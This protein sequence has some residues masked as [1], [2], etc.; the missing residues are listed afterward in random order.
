[1]KRVVAVLAALMM[2][3]VLAGTASAYPR[4]PHN[5]AT[6][7][8][9]FDWKISRPFTASYVASST[10]NVMDSDEFED[11]AKLGANHDPTSATVIVHDMHV[12]NKFAICYVEAGAYQKGFPDDGNFAVTDYGAT[13]SYPNQHFNRRYQMDGYPDEYYLNIAGFAGYTPGATL[14]GTAANI[15]TALGQRIA[16]CHAEGMDGVEPDDLDGYT[17]DSASGAMGGG[18]RLTQ[19]EAAG[20]EQWLAYTAHGDSMAIFQKNDGANTAADYRT[21]DGMI[22]EE[23]NAY[24]DPCGADGDNV[25]DYVNAGKPVLNAE[26]TQDGE[27]T[28]QFC[29]ADNALGINGSLFSVDLDGSLY[30]SCTKG[31]GYVYGH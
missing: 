15:A 16:G 17:N 5:S 9:Q 1:M 11:A 8:V 20:F 30:A 18:W 24:D 31:R 22:I 23:C 29:S 2:T 26:Y 19:A 12:A 27:T 14:T 6:V 10:A 28:A 21:F 4:P 25:Q 3:L 7:T 13:G